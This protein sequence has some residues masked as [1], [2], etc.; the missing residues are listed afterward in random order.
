MQQNDS[1]PV[2]YSALEVSNI[3]GVVNQTAINWI[4]NGYLKAFKTPGGQFRVYPDDLADF[5]QERKMEIP[6]S[7]LK[8]C[9]SPKYL[10]KRLLIVDDDKGLNIVIAK[11]MEQHLPGVEVYQAFDG[12]EAGSFMTEIHPACLILDLDLPGIDGI[13]LCKKIYE[14]DKFGK[15]SIIVV[16]ALESQD[17]EKEVLGFGVKSFF[18]KPI[19][20]NSLQKLVAE[21]F[22]E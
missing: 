2:M 12:F 4:R 21:S 22:G 17:V 16:T 6:E 15:P 9:K 14:T 20:L 19:D 3:C 5:M 1:K 13:G 7:L 18:K 11:Y 10:K 8:A